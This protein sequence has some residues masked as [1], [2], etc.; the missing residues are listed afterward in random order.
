MLPIIDF[1]EAA[2]CR[3]QSFASVCGGH[4]GGEKE[5]LDIW[6]NTGIGSGASLVGRWMETNLPAQIK[7]MKSQ[8]ADLQLFDSD[9]DLQSA[10]SRNKCVLIAALQTDESVP[11][12]FLE[13]TVEWRNSRGT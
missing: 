5:R 10:I 9:F 8:R 2:L 3:I 13:S 6:G 11:T 4:D 7:D 1:A 12:G